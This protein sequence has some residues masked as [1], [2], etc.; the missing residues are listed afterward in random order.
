MNHEKVFSNK[1]SLIKKC[2]YSIGIGMGI[3]NKKNIVV[4]RNF[5]PIICKGSN[6]PC[7]KSKSY[8]TLY[9]NQSSTVIRFYQG[10]SKY[11]DDNLLIGELT[12]EDI[13]KSLAGRQEVRIILSYYNHGILEISARLLS[14]DQVYIKTINTLEVEKDIISFEESIC[15]NNWENYELSYMVKA[16]IKY[17]EE[18]IQDLNIIETK[19]MGKVI[20]KIKKYLLLNNRDMVKKHKK[21]LIYLLSQIN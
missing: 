16:V 9:D 18:V 6:I 2:H 1:T 17:G 20:K 15:Y 12:I 14:T 10:N 7:I 13:P 11:V 5:D 8:Y 4:S 3:R 21:E 19:K